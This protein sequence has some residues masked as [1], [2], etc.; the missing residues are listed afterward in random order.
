MLLFTKIAGWHHQSIVDGVNAV[1]VLAEKHHFDYEWHEDAN[2]FTDNN[3][4]RFLLSVFGL[5]I[6]SLAFVGIHQ[7]LGV[8]FML[9]SQ[10]WDSAYSLYSPYIVG[11]T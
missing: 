3:L 4:A 2:Q 5:I 7:R 1:K 8:A 9:V 6:C 11:S 10:A